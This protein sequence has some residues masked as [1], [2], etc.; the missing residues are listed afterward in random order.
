[1]AK[2]ILKE[3]TPDFKITTK[4]Q[5]SEQHGTGIKAGH[6]N[7]SNRNGNPKINPHIYNQLNFYK[8]DKTIQYGMKAFSTMMLDN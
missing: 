5:Q 2:T 4:L 8:G 6:S 7:Q 3:N 1:M